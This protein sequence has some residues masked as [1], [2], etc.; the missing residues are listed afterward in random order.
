MYIYTL[1]PSTD[2]QSN[3][4]ADDLEGWGSHSTETSL[5]CPGLDFLD[6]FD[7]FLTSFLHYFCSLALG[8]IISLVVP[9]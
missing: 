1:L 7:N 4:S 2:T 6:V 8:S 5:G 9:I 3:K